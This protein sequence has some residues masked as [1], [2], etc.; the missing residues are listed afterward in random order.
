MRFMPHGHCIFWTPGVLWP[1]VLSDLAIAVAYFAI[2]IVLWRAA[3]GTTDGGL[4]PTRWMTVLF[5]SFIVLCGLTH[6][7]GVVT[8][9]TPAWRL[10]NVVK[11]AT[12]VVS[13]ATAW[14]LRGAMQRLQV[15]TAARA[16]LA[17][18]Q[19]RVVEDA[20][21]HPADV[22]AL[23]RAVRRVEEATRGLGG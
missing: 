14:A 4:L 20:E 1:S 16:A 2:P 9:W 8:M 18:E 6:V 12:A 5:C 21:D 23:R 22:R 10:A 19:A 11:A 17:A 15:W 13:L 7:M 3:R